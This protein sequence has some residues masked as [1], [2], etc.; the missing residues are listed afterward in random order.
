MPTQKARLLSSPSSD[1]SHG[2]GTIRPD[3]GADDGDVITS[4]M[5]RKK[6][7]RDDAVAHYIAYP[8]RWVVL[9]AFSFLSFMN[10]WCWITWSPLALPLSEYWHVHTSKV[11]DLSAVFMY[12]YI[13]LSF[14]A[15]LALH[16][17]KLTWGLWVGGT[18]NFVGALVRYWKMESYPWVYLGTFL[19]ACCQ[20]L[21]LAMPPLI[22]T[23][24][25][26]EKERG[27]ATSLGVLANQLG[28]A[29]GLGVT[30][31]VDF[32]ASSTASSTTVLDPGQQDMMDTSTIRE[33]T[34]R[35]YLG[36]QMILSA[37]SLV[38]IAV[39]VRSNA[40]P[41][42][43]SEAASQQK[44]TVSYL[45]SIRLFLV[46]NHPSGSIL[47]IVYGLAVGVLYAL[48]TF[49][50]QFFVGNHAMASGSWT[51]TEAGYLGMLLIMAGLPGSILAGEW[52]DK[53]KHQE[54][55]R[56]SIAYL[57]FSF[58]SVTGFPFFLEFQA[59]DRWLA[60]LTIACM[61]FFLTGFI[62]VG[63]EYG[64]AISYPADEAA[65]AGVLNV[66]AQIGG[67]VLVMVGGR[68]GAG[69]TL[70]AVLATSVFVALLLLVFFV[71]A[72]SA[73]PSDGT[74]I[75]IP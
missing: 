44:S 3:G 35:Q 10:N 33:S 26:Q 7:K 65:V 56:I 74:S 23:S 64:T 34:L 15:L 61:G 46:T 17:Y 58:G 19:C 18:L 29:F 59:C 4:P 67:W 36:L 28:S 70:N 1:E 49:L 43:P 71:R 2:Y 68:V 55:R 62:T 40:P 6:E 13:P 72:K 16:K 48:A 14:P 38:L 5:E 11:D 63:F 66:A 12:V 73:R 54:H 25:F 27:L 30:M 39:F 50:S 20:T 42:P 21:T 32:S 57:L 47:C 60:Y 53:T 45:E 69:E 75:T 8:Q 51:E 41:T 9:A 52:L 31:V 24:W 22:S 37:L